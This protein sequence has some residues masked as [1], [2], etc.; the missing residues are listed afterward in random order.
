MRGKSRQRRD[1]TSGK[2]I[3]FPEYCRPFPTGHDF[4]LS[5]RLFFEILVRHAGHLPSGI[6]PEE[7]LAACFETVER[8]LHVFEGV[9]CGQG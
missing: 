9:H 8:V 6:R 7:L 4:M 1:E 2:A 5:F 3:A